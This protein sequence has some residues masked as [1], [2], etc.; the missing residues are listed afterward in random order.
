MGTVSVKFKI[1][2]SSPS[3]NLEKIKEK[4]KIVLEKH[5][6]KNP[7]FVEEPIAFGLKAVIVLFA[8]SE[9]KSLD[10]IESLIAKIPDVSSVQMIDIRRAFG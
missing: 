4:T 3:T 8:F 7:S 2:P 1:M 10:E 6:G 5:G 9:E